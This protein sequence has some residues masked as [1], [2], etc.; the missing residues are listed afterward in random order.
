MSKVEVINQLIQGIQF[1]D[2]RLYD[3][4]RAISNK[5]AELDET[6]N[7][8][9]SAISG[10]GTGIFA[11][12][13][14]TDFTYAIV[15]QKNLRLMWSYPSGLVSAEIKKWPVGTVGAWE[16]GDT[17]LISPST[18]A[19]FDPLETGVHWYAIK[20]IDGSGNR[21]ADVTYLTVSVNPIGTII[22]T[23]D[24]I[25]NNVL[26]KWNE[27]SSPWEISYYEVYKD[28]IEI[29]YNEGNFTT[30]FEVVSG[31]Y[32]YGIIAY[33][34]A[35]NA[36]AMGTVNAQ[37]RQ[38]PDYSLQEQLS[39]PNLTGTKTDV[40]L[41]NGKLYC[42]LVNE[43]W[44]QH[45]VNNSWSDIDDQ[46]NAGYPI[47]AEPT[48]ITGQYERE[49]HCL[50]EYSNTIIN[51][52]YEANQIFGNTLIATEI[53]VAP[54]SHVYG[55]WNSGR[56]YFASLVEWV[57]VRFTFTG[58]DNKSLLEFGNFSVTMDV[59]REV[60]SGNI[61]AIA[62]DAGG[63]QVNFNKA[64]KDVDSITLVAESAEP[65]YPVYDFTD[66]PNPTGF[67]VLVF[68]SAGKRISKLISWKA[69]GIV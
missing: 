11:P 25:D 48:D 43:T 8:L 52:I 68:D 51:V 18:S 4:L 2:I 21:T 66:I 16:T 47:Y 60:D 34:I 37:V 67:K 3:A 30:I 53:A 39:D 38:P 33:D 24:V 40:V 58:D 29:G 27:P 41:M 10:E 22:V 19:L 15:N 46:I 17:V 65:I 61:N 7:T 14:I 54:A 36:S 57:K 49:F 20:G 35:G 1:E 32:E 56:S 55:S 12:G 9:R 63:T 6:D 42:S 62:T 13:K 5:L 26:L 69:R 23:A 44:Q 31:T 50:A 59:K 64:F 28:G 45:F